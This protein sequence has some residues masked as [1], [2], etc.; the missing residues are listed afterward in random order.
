MTDIQPEMTKKRLIDGLDGF[1]SLVGKTLFTSPPIEITKE[2]IQAYCKSVGNREWVHWDEAA[3]RKSGLEGLI[4][5]GLFIPSLYPQLFWDHIELKNVPGIIVKG[6]DKI[7]ILRPI[8]MGTCLTLSS[9]ITKCEDRNKGI[10]VHYEV[11]FDEMNSD[12]RL[13]QAVFIGRY[14]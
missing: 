12:E 9:R 3:S 1:R 10:E 4:A 13:G 2:K 14:W 6:I 5:P 8:Y 11:T 7:R